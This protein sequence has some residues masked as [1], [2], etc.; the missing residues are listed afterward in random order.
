MKIFEVIGGTLPQDDI[1][2]AIQEFV[3]RAKARNLAKISTPML[4]G[5]LQSQGFSIEME[6]LIPIL[7]SI[8]SVGSANEKTVTLDIAIPPSVDD[9]EDDTVS[10]LASRQMKKDMK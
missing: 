1:I 4:L 3:A 9:P 5:K 2:D 10:K 7:S 8:S 6:T